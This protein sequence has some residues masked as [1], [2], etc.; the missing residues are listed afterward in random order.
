MA[1]MRDGI[2]ISAVGFAKFISVLFCWIVVE[3]VATFSEKLLF[4]AIPVKVSSS[5]FVYRN[6]E[7]VEGRDTSLKFEKL[8]YPI[9][10]Q[11]A[12]E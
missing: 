9:V 10:V 6:K 1:N 12:T 5:I 4:G 11:E 7:E 2:T 3:A 8:V